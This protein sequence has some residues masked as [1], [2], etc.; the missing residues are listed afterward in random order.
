MAPPPIFS[1][2]ELPGEA[3]GWQD[4]AFAN[5]FARFVLS[6][7][8]E[9]LFT[10]RFYRR[11]RQE[12]GH[13]AHYDVHGFYAE[14]FATTADR[15]RF[16]RHTLGMAEDGTRFCFPYDTTERA[17][18]AWV[19]RSRL[20]TFWEA[21]LGQETLAAKR[22]LLATLKTELEPLAPAASVAPSPAPLPFPCPAVVAPAAAPQ[23]KRRTPTVADG[24]MRFDLFA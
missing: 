16:I 3:W 13:I 7:F 18:Q 5:H 22:E 8:K 11:L 10:T 15:V 17:I 24:Q 20:L 23:R 21:R 1:E 19:R 2:A 4:A 9:T 12:F 6:G 14:W